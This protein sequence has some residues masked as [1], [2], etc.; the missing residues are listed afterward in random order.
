MLTGIIIFLYATYL[1][2]TI[3][4]GI[5][6]IISFLSNHTECTRV[7]WTPPLRESF[8]YPLLL[9]QMYKVTK[10][11]DHSRNDKKNDKF[12]WKSFFD[13]P[14]LDILVLTEVCLYS[15]QFS[16]FIM[17]TQIIALLILQW[18]KII[19]RDIAV[20]ITLIHLIAISFSVIQGLMDFSSLYTCLVVS[21]IYSNI[22]N[23]RIEDVFSPRMLLLSDITTTIGST[24][25]LKSSLTNSHDYN[26]VFDILESKLTNYKNFHTMLYTCSVEFD[27]FKY[28]T[29]EIIMKTFLLPS[30]ILAGF[31]IVY[32]WYRNYKKNGYPLCIE[33]GVAY[34][35]LQ[36][37]AFIIMAV[38]VMRLKLFMTPH[39][40]I[41]AG[42]VV[43]E[44]YLLKL[45][46]KYKSA[47]FIALIC[48]I[49]YHGVQRFQ[50]ERQFHGNFSCFF[51]F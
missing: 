40:C 46:I 20:Q 6:A 32:Y 43:G 45:G 18:T 19:T 33:A 2:G 42:M 15:W 47:I 36:T 13:C 5:I 30:A 1:S 3:Y 44:R 31:L 29:L 17:I 41:V 24:H 23:S 37:I 26:H 27:F 11:L 16:Q 48:A 35:G 12:S 28:E 10:L 7:Q 51:L 4:G 49:S 21:T 14:Y 34:N 39:L 25:L 9:F 38:L 22:I 8:A 50:E